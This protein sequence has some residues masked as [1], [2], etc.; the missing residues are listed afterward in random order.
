M[1]FTIKNAWALKESDSGKALWVEVSEVAEKPVWIPHS[2]IHAD[3][4]V[5]KAGHYGKL[6]ISDWLAEKEGWAST[7]PG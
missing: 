2:Q 1:P 5:Y 6:V 4:E 7:T 3:S